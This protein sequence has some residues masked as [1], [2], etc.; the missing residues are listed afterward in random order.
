VEPIAVVSEGEGP[1]VLLVHGGATPETTW[2]GLEPLRARWRLSSVYRRNFPPSPPARDGRADFDVDASDL[3]PL[4]RDR[5]HVV[6]HSYGGLGALIAAGRAP[7]HVR[8]LTIIESPVYL[9]PDDPHVARVQMLGDTFLTQ[10]LDM[11]PVLLR[12]FLRGAG[13]DVAGSEPLPERVVGSIRRSQGGRS[14]SEAR[15]ALGAIRVAGVPV[16]VASGAHTT[17]LERIC[18]AL[19]A[20]LGGERVVAPGAGHFVARAPGFA[21]QLERFLRAAGTMAT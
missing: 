18:D 14:P 11:D 4:L 12:E 7:E 16:L 13:V 6:A 17:G 8:S 2:A 21:E 20:E 15:P 9:T 19:A 5:P 10:G 1:E 3:A